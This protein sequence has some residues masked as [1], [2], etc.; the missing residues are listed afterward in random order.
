MGIHPFIS[1]LEK[2]E[3]TLYYKISN[4]PVIFDSQN[5][6]YKF[7]GKVRYSSTR[8]GRS[9]FTAKKEPAFLEVKDKPINLFTN[10]VTASRGEKIQ[11]FTDSAHFKAGRRNKKILKN[12][13]NGL[14]IT[15]LPTII[16]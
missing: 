9:I 14:L 7:L 8:S 16:T 12:W 4:V 6:I 2:I 15:K 3:K 5:G 10:N 11:T 1:D 13:K